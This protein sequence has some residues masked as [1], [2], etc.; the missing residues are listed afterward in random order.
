MHPPGETDNPEV[1]LSERRSDEGRFLFVVNNTTPDS[2]RAI[3]RALAV[4]GD[5]CT[6]RGTRAT[7]VSG[8]AVYDV[9]AGKQVDANDGMVETDLRDLPARIFAVLPEA[10]HSVSS[11]GPVMDSS[12]DESSPGRSSCCPHQKGSARACR[13]RCS[14][15]IVA[16]T[17]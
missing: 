7:W 8:G 10:I 13:Y 15:A 4:R 2:S 6:G 1:F 11:A 9:F 14:F 5:A 3:F 17:S 12:P 16:A